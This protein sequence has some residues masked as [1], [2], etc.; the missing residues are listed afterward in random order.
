MPPKEICPCLVAQGLGQLCRVNDVAE[1]K[2]AASGCGLRSG[3]IGDLLIDMRN[4]RRRPES[5]EGKCCRIQFQ[6]RTL[7]V[8][9]E[10]VTGGEQDSCPCHL[11][12]RV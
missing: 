7:G 10:L 9:L 5:I 11:I 3:K 8:S 6:A 2:G 1:Q 4:I 12:G